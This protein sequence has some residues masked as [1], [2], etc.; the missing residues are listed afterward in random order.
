MKLTLLLIAINVIVFVNTA[1]NLEHYLDQYGFSINSF[2]EGRYYTLITALFMH[3]NIGHL[4][5]N[6]IALL[7]LGGS[8]ESKAGMFKYLLAYFLAGISGVFSAF[9]PIFGYSPDTVFVGASGAISGL[10]GFGIFTS[11]GSLIFFPSIIPVPF[12][13]A[14]ALYLLTTI[15]LLFNQTGVAYPAHLFG[16]LTGMTFGLLFGEKRIKRL[17]IFIIVLVLIVL[18]P[19]ILRSLF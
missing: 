18:G 13:I 6:M 5:A 14:S 2:L 10:I 3:F 17:L 11:P 7:I 1:G 4:L 16:L 15:S 9:V 8:V 19:A 12:V